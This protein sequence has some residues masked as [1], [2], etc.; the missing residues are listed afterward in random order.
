MGS[1]WTRIWMLCFW[2]WASP[3]VLTAWVGSEIDVPFW[4]V[5]VKIWFSFPN[6]WEKKDAKQHHYFIWPRQKNWPNLRFLSMGE[7]VCLDTLTVL[8][9]VVNLCNVCALLP[10]YPSL[11]WDNP[12]TSKKWQEEHVFICS[13]AFSVWL[14]H[15][16]YSCNSDWIP[17]GLRSW[18]SKNENK[19]TF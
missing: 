15:F 12:D 13:L 8:Q 1:K 7:S 6:A 10:E 5:P 9:E 16:P 18:W 11:E 14:T 2:Q 4:S 3:C 17:W 19:T